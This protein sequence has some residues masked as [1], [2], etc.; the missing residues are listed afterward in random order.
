MSK[1][2]IKCSEDKPLECYLFRKD[3][4][5]YVNECKTCAQKRINA[6]RR[7]NEAYKKRYNEYRKKRRMEDHTYAVKDRLRARLRKMIK[8]Q[9]ASKYTKT[10]EFLGCS[11]DDFVEHIK[12]QFFGDM[13]W[14]KRNFV[15]DH[16]V[17]ICWFD[18]TNENHQRICFHY[19]NIQPL[20][21]EDNTI[22][23]VRVWVDYDIN[24]NPY[25]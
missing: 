21:H 7:D 22:K 3:R 23:G 18:L 19:T 9:D 6:Y 8:A 20:T 4:Q 16:K 5:K 15:L 10:L 2:C 13:C 14:E 11:W 12:S 1:I 24:K 17:P 25:I